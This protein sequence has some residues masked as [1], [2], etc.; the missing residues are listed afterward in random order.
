MT[1]T[2]PEAARA[3]SSPP[4]IRSPRRPAR[5]SCATAATPSTPRSRR[6]SPRGWPSRCSPARARAATCSSPARAGS[7]RCSTSSSPRPGVGAGRRARPRSSRSRSTSRR[8]RAGVP[9]RRRVVRRPT[10]PR[11]ASTAAVERW[12]SMPLAELA[13]PAAALARDGVVGQR[14]RRRYLFRI[15]LPAIVA[16]LA[17]GRGDVPARRAAAAAGRAL[18]LPELGDAI[19]RLGARARRRST[20]A[21]SPRRSSP[22]SPSAADC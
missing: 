1:G 14:R 10:A 4:G 19:E 21:T 18:P 20:P 5:A 22:G 16:Q 8:R 2:P 7:R 11:R 6:C 9:R 15:L 3:A 12:G 17:G 13:A